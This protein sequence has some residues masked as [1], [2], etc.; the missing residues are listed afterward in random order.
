MNTYQIQMNC[1]QISYLC[2]FFS[3]YEDE[4]IKTSLLSSNRVQAVF[5]ATTALQIREAVMHLKQVFQ[6]SKFGPGL[7]YTIKNIS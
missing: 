5:E 6:Q 1:G 4:L 2:D 7:Y 3:V